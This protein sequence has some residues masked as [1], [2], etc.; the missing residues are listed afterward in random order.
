MAWPPAEN[1]SE[2]SKHNIEGTP[3]GESL[4][5]Q[6]TEVGAN[7]DIYNNS[8]SSGELNEYIENSPTSSGQN[9]QERP[10]W[11]GTDFI[12][13]QENTSVNTENETNE[14]MSKDEDAEKHSKA[15][16]ALLDE[17]LQDPA[18]IMEMAMDE[19]DPKL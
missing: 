5:E 7:P 1:K 3:T 6:I 17:G 15:L 4:A 14:V 12:K 9:T 16:E 13:P 8:T 19:A 18:G 11:M 10:D 2:L